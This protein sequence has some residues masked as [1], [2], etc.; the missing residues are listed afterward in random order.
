LI[1]VFL[2][3][4]ICLFNAG[5]DRDESLI[6]FGTYKES[7]KLENALKEISSRGYTEPETFRI[8]LLID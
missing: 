8:G 5:V 4:N 6:K 7:N 3:R 2:N 1:K